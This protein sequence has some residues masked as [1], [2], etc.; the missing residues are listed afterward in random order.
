MPSSPLHSASR[1][2]RPT[3]RSSD[4]VIRAQWANL[5]PHDW[6]AVFATAGGLVSTAVSVHAP[7]RL[8]AQLMAE[9]GVPADRR[10]ADLRRLERIGDRKST[11]LNSSHLV[12][13]YAVFSTPLR[14]STLSPYP[15]LFRSSDSCAMG[16][17]RPARL[18]GGVRHRRWACEHC[19]ICTCSAAAGRSVDGRS[20][21]A[22]GSP[23]R[24]S[25]PPRAHRRSE[26]HTSELQSPC[27]LV[28]RLLHSTPHLDTLALPDALPI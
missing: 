22:G 14:I 25:A 9:V 26:E 4:L 1:H 5:D 13:S 28:C 11:R 8:V 10:A 3:R 27:H 2:S 7:Q 23:G 19:G 16:Q 15:T 6:E 20:W 18:G 17:S 21:C 12:I 24:R